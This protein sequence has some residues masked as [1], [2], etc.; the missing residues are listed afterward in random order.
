MRQSRGRR[1]SARPAA[2]RGCGRGSASSEKVGRR[3]L[4]SRKRFSVRSYTPGRRCPSR[5]QVSPSDPPAREDSPSAAMLPLHGRALSRPVRTPRHPHVPGARTRPEHLRPG[6]ARSSSAAHPTGEISPSLPRAHR[7]DAPRSRGGAALAAR[8]EHRAPFLGGA[9]VI[10]LKTVQILDE[11]VD[12]AALHRPETVGYNVEWSQEL[13]LEA[14][15]RG[16]R[17]GL[18]AHRDPGGQRHA[19]PR[20]GAARDRLRHER[21]LR[22]RAGFKHDRR[23]RPSSAA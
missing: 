6:R 22:P 4:A 21:R 7:G 13:K 14:V 3:I 11:L 8:P 17:Q 16:V 23:A 18:D 9:R 5:G 12:P 10:E 15:A 19:R 20:P 2:L 1:H